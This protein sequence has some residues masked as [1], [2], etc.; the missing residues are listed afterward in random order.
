MERTETRDLPSPPLLVTIFHYS[1]PEGMLGRGLN[2]YQGTGAD[3]LQ[4]PLRSRF[5][6]RLTAS[7]RVCRDKPARCERVQVSDSE[8]LANHAGP[9]SCAG[10]GNGVCEALTGER[11]G[12]V[13]SPEMAH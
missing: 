2:K 4:R 3:A 9:E 5:Q 1:I 7:V 11:A 8:G 12:R 6:A 10:F 13:E